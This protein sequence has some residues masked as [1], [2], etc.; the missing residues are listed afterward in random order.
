MDEFAHAFLGCN[1]IQLSNVLRSYQSQKFP[2]GTFKIQF[3][4][5]PQRSIHCWRTLL[6][7]LEACSFIWLDPNLS[8]IGRVHW[9]NQLVAGWTNPLEKYYTV[10]MDHFPQEWTMKN[11]FETTTYLITKKHVAF[12]C[13]YV[14]QSALAMSLLGDHWRCLC[15]CS[16]IWSDKT[17]LKK[18]NIFGT[19]IIK[20]A[21]HSGC[22]ERHY[23]KESKSSHSQSA[24]K[25]TWATSSCVR[26][27]GASVLQ[28]LQSPF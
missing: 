11:I 18:S 23:P 28:H 19:K 20:P 5:L 21:D 26:W 9:L 17:Y 25:E 16:F 10:K 27:F 7:S 3:H 14:A 24:P 12:G 2:P 22:L 15:I 6:Q 4:L 8:E 13:D 1:Y